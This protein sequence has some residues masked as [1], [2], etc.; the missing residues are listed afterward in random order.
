MVLF[1]FG[2][3]AAA[4]IILKCEAA[5]YGFYLLVPGLLC[6]AVLWG[7][8]LPG[9]FGNAP[10]ARACGA[11]MLAA[12]A[13]AHFLRTQELTRLW[14]GP[15][16]PT[17]VHTARGTMSC[18]T[19]YKGTVDEAIRFLQDKP[20]TTKVI[21]LPEGCGITFLA[22]CTNPLGLFTYLPIDFS[23]S[24]DNAATVKQF[25]KADPDFILLTARDMREYGANSFID[26]AKPVEE[27][28]MANYALVRHFRTERYMVTV[29]GRNRA[30]T[31]PAVG[32]GASTSCFARP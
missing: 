24:Y 19:P 23:G 12:L 28:V 11:A 5:H 18:P 4:R 1:T 17:V 22:G 3:A 13:W 8:L 31:S 14:Y 26:Y 29:M 25:G 16:K 9:W 7:R 10:S 2:L 15:G 20:P 27:W 32:D 21:V 30:T 6:F